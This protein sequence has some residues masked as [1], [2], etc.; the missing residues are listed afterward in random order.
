MS[1][2]QQRL[3]DEGQKVYAQIVDPDR[4]FNPSAEPLDVEAAC[5]DAHLKASTN[6]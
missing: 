6:D 5:M 3:H 2:F 1:D 4:N